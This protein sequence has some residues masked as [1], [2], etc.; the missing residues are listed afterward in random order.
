MNRLAAGQPVTGYVF[1]VHLVTAD[2][3]D[4]DG[5]DRLRYDPDDGYRDIY[6]RIW[7]RP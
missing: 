3:V 1:P 6:R 2:N 5:G 4:A 7:Q